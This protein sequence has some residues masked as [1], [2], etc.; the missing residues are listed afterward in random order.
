MSMSNNTNNSDNTKSKSSVSSN[1][2]N[3]IWK[4][5]DYHNNPTK[6][7][8]LIELA[9][10]ASSQDNNFDNA[11]KYVKLIKSTWSKGEFVKECNAWIVKRDIN[12]NDSGKSIQWRRLPLH[13]L[14][15]RSQQS[16]SSS[17][18]SNSSNNSNVIKEIITVMLSENDESI[19][20]M[21][22]YGRLPLHLACIYSTYNSFSII[23]TLI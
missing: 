23:E 17:S 16:S 7:F 2:N 4:Y 5:A 14:C 13:E 18:S 9:S 22:S 8:Q 10:S 6:L 12:N 11:L 21:D 20:S 15:I 3:S 1:N 19:K